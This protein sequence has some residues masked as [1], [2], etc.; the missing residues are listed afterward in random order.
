MNASALVNSGTMKP[1]GDAS[2]EQQ[3]QSQLIEANELNSPLA[4]T[5]NPEN[6]QLDKSN[7]NNSSNH[8]N[9]KNQSEFSKSPPLASNYNNPSNL[10]HSESITKKTF[11]VSY[12][13]KFSKFNFFNL[14]FCV[15]FYELNFS[16]L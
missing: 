10:L 4:D 15:Y 12:F 14:E 9:N 1:A 7:Y 8:N 3:T 11:D 2:N 5:S 16:T 6:H 13:L